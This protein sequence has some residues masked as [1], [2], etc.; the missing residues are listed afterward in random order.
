MSHK[1]S[2]SAQRIQP[3]ESIQTAHP[4]VHIFVLLHL[5]KEAFLS[6]KS[7]A[8]IQR[9]VEN[10]VVVHVECQLLSIKT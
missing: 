7:E 9:F 2:E 5:F 4:Q 10:K 3:T 8:Y 6:K 1:Y